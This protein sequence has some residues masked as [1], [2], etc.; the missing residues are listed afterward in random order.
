MGRERDCARPFNFAV[1]GLT[2]EC[3]PATEVLADG[4]RS[5]CI[6][7]QPHQFPLLLSLAPA[8]VAESPKLSMPGAAPGRLA[9][10]HFLGPWQKSDA[11]GLQAGLKRER[12]P[13]V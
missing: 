1:V 9:I 5:G 4:H 12:Y 8:C 10:F 3:L 7:R 13:S 6:S 11:P 2:A